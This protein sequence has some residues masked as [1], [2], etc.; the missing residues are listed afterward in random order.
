[1]KTN[2]HNKIIK[3]L[4]VIRDKSARKLDESQD[5]EEI[6][7]HSKNVIIEIE[8]GDYRESLRILSHSKSRNSWKDDDFIDFCRDVLLNGT[9]FDQITRILTVSNEL[10]LFSASEI[11]DFPLKTKLTENRE[12]SKKLELFLFAK[13]LLILYYDKFT[14]LKDNDLINL[15]IIDYTFSEQSDFEVFLDFVNYLIPILDKNDDFNLIELLNEKFFEFY[16]YIDIINPALGTHSSIFPL[17][18]DKSSFP[19]EKI[20]EILDSNIELDE[21]IRYKWIYIILKHSSIEIKKSRILDTIRKNI[22]IYDIETCFQAIKA[23]TEIVL[24]S[25]ECAQEAIMLGLADFCFERMINGPSILQ[26]PS[27]DFFLSIMRYVDKPDIEDYFEENQIL[28]KLI[29][30][31]EWVD[32]CLVYKII[33]EIIGMLNVLSYE[34]PLFISFAESDAHETLTKFCDDATENADEFENLNLEEM[35]L[36]IESDYQRKETHNFVDLTKY[37]AVELIEIIDN[38]FSNFL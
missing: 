16:M 12:N 10:K 28:N 7:E 26:I 11:R 2:F 4:D 30:N 35:Y 18:I 13:Q 15:L 22:D 19:F 37:K 24:G 8:E 34:N 1:M 33:N 31:I 29:N 5:N 20:K 6:I 14:E 32:H 38:M 25:A 27:I 3:E 21:S 9:D 36:N 17:L 23:S